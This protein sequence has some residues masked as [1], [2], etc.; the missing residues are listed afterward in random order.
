MHSINYIK[1]AVLTHTILHTEAQ[2]SFYISRYLF[3]NGLK[4]ISL[5][6]FQEYWELLP[7]HVPVT[8]SRYSPEPA[9]SG[10]W[11]CHYYLWEVCGLTAADENEC[12]PPPKIISA[13]ARQITARS[14]YLLCVNLESWKVQE[15]NN[16]RY[17]GL[18]GFMYWKIWARPPRVH[19]NISQCHLG[20]A[21]LREKFWKIWKKKKAREKIKWKRK[22]IYMGDIYAKRWQVCRGVCIVSIY[23][24][25]GNKT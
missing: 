17:C 15:L 13:L 11:W 24:S 22:G 20:E 5:Y 14:G 10:Y 21:D 3:S 25:W 19:A 16:A 6:Y 8:R 4:K 23:F 2:H 1:N 12:R 9:L 18:Q 7:G